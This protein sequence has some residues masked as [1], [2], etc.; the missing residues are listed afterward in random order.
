MVC[1]LWKEVKLSTWS[2][3]RQKSYFCFPLVI[4][5]EGKQNFRFL[6]LT[7]N[8]QK[9]STCQ[10][11]PSIVRIRVIV[12]RFCRLLIILR[13][14]S[15]LSWFQT[16]ILFKTQNT[17]PVHLFIYL[18]FLQT[19]ILRNCHYRN[20]I[21]SSFSDKREK[22]KIPDGKANPPNVMSALACPALFI[23]S[24]WFM[25]CNFSVWTYGII[26]QSYQ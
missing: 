22:M 19:W 14:R 1:G 18:L 13:I 11:K 26:I 6:P 17:K 24:C 9:L 7:S 12:T 20:A 8:S 2:R 15:R 10:G 23:P 3:A 21:G 25:V 5:C 16:D 4:K